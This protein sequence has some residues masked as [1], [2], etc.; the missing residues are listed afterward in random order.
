MSR[1]RRSSWRSGGYVTRQCSGPSR[2]V[3]LLWFVSR[4]G[5]G[6]ATD[7]PYVIPTGTALGLKDTNSIDIVTKAMPGDICKL[8][9][10]V[11]DDGMI[12]DELQRYKLLIEKLTAY[13]NYVASTEF[14]STHPG[15][16]FGDVLV[17]VL[18][19]IPPNEAMSDVQA[20]GA[21]GD[22]QNRLKVVFADYD[23]FMAGPKAG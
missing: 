23:G 12:T 9:L 17:R 10:F 1:M 2:R 22:L 11:V 21:K 7:R 18:C 4:R 15:V 14:R 3:S 8:V 6:S 5:D 19:K 16:G 20:I 13:V